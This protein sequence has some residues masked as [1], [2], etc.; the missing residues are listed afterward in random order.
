MKTV[1]YEQVLAME[2]CWLYTAQGRRRLKRYMARLGGEATAVDILRLSRVPMDERF[3]LV[4]REDFI[5]ATILHEFACRCA[6]RALSWIENPNPRSV[7]ASAA[8]RAWLRGEISDEELDAAM[9]AAMGAAM[10]ASGH[11]ARA[12]AF[13]AAWSAAGDAARHSAWNAAGHATR[14]AA[15]AAAEDAAWA[16]AWAAERKWQIQ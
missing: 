2:P 5:P 12:A 1:T 6:E 7:A 16:A 8:K 3:W 13:A 10:A 15:W 4:L 14:T 11:A 9:T